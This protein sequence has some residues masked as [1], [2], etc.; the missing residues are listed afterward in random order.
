MNNKGLRPE[1][2]PEEKRLRR[3]TARDRRLPIP[4]AIIT[5]VYKGRELEV[6]VLE[7][8][9]EFEGKFYKT[10]SGVATA[11]TGVSWNGYLFFKP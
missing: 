10:L 2:T 5:K 9:F 8:G 4:G 7:Q 3:V 1:G 11:L 6:K